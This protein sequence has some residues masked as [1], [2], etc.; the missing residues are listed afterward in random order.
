MRLVELKPPITSEK[1]HDVQRDFTIS[2]L[3]LSFSSHQ[4][5]VLSEAPDADVVGDEPGLEDF[6]LPVAFRP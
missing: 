5:V 6:I 1:P 3:M 4:I 2:C